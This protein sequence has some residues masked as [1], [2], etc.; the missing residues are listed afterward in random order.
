MRNLSQTTAS[1]VPFPAAPRSFGRRSI[2]SVVG[3]LTVL[4]L[5]RHGETATDLFVSDDD[6]AVGAVWIPKAL[7]TV[8]ETRGRFLV[9]TI[10]ANLAGQRRLS[11]PI[12]DRSRFTPDELSELND[13]V[14]AAARA[15]KRLCGYQE[16]MGWSGGRNVF[17]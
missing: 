8:D 13:A 2:S 5:F 14:S 10:A 12:I 11:T 16:A 4:M 3:H 7:V 9:V 15:R 17:A 1:I 6:D